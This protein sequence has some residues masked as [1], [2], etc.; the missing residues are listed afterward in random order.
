[1]NWGEFLSDVRNDLRDTAVSPRWSDDLLY[2]YAKDGI[3]GY[4]LWFPKRVD[5]VVIARQ[6]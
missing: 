5:R 3:R 6:S 2:L 1:M 4:S